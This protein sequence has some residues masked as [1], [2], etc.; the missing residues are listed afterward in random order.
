MSHEVFKTVPSTSVARTVKIEPTSGSTP[1]LA[2][3][4]LLTDYQITRSATGELT[5]QSPGSLADG[6]VPTWS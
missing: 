6:T 2:C 3:E 4:A 1:Y 5:W